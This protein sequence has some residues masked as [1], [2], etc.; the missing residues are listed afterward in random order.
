MYETEKKEFSFKTFMKRTMSDPVLLYTAL[1]MMSIMYHYRSSLTLVYGIV[2]YIIGWFLIRLFD[3]VDKHR[4]LGALAYGAVGVL[5]LMCMRACINKGHENYPILWGL[6]FLTP[7]TAV[8]YNKW[9][10]IAV[11]ILFFMFMISVI[12]YFTRR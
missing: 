3:F 11:Y 8:Q 5:S 7:Q 4:F 9:Y 2:T 6:W 10:T 1:I 12:Y